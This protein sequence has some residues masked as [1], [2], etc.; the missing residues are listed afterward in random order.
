MKPRDKREFSAII[1]K[2]GGKIREIK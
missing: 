2:T 1:R